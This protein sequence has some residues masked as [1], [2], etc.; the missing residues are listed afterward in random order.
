MKTYLRIMAIGFGVAFVS[1]I[2][3]IVLSATHYQHDWLIWPLGL[4]ALVFLFTLSW[5]PVAIMFHRDV[6]NKWWF[7]AFFIGGLLT[8]KT[9]IGPAI[10]IGELIW[11]CTA[12]TWQQREI[13]ATKLP[14]PPP[15]PTTSLPP[16]SF[17][18]LR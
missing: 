2:A 10:W 8:I 7:W 4:G 17:S 18:E 13:L 16:A 1:F 5:V 14:P 12:I 11:A 3:L 6:A 15:K 9:G